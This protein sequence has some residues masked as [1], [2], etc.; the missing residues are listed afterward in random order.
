MSSRRLFDLTFKLFNKTLNPCRRGWY[1]SLFGPASGNLPEPL[2]RNYTPPG[3]SLPMS[4]TSTSM[5]TDAAAS[6]AAGETS[7]P[8]AA[9][10]AA[11]ATPLTVSSFQN[12]QGCSVSSAA[13]DAVISCNE[14]A[15]SLALATLDVPIDSAYL[16]FEYRFDPVG[17]GEH[18]AVLIDDRP[19]W[20][21]PGTLG[22]ANTFQLT[23]G[24]P[25][26]G[27]SGTR[28]LTVAFYGAGVAT[29]HFELRH[30]SVTDGAPTR[31]YLAEAATGSFFDTRFAVLNTNEQPTT[32]TLRFL[33]DD[34]TSTSLS[35]TLAARTRATFDPKS[36][37]GMASASFST[38]VESGLPVVVDRQMTWDATGYG[39]HGHSLTRDDVVSRRRID[40]RRFRTVL[41]AAESAIGACNGHDSLPAP[42]WAGTDREDVR[43]GRELAD[44][45]CRGWRRD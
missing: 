40:V 43:A 23:S 5:S 13:A 10:A 11:S 17:D 44:D 39:S 34:G 31:R 18:A 22:G 24:I 21:L 15:A 16:S 8:V 36:V 1:L 30:L 3:T 38:V 12:I 41:F 27:L 26:G 19:V 6:V 42:V 32:V 4:L 7:A 25:I 2:D 29:G 37:D 45:D 14:T 20:V 28:T 9:V 33:K 35:R